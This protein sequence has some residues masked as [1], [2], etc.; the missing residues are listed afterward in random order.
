VKLNRALLIFSLLLTSVNAGAQQEPAIKGAENMRLTGAEDPATSKVYIVQ[1]RA[2]SAAEHHASLTKAY[3]AA[4][5]SSA[6]SRP[7]F[8]KNSPSISTTN[9]NAC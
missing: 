3:A 1:L 6:A 7:R 9:S 4:K 8:D 5:I 2:P